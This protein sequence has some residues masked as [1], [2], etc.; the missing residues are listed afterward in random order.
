MLFHNEKKFRLKFSLESKKE[1]A[2]DAG[3][4]ASIVLLGYTNL[5][6]FLFVDVAEGVANCSKEEFPCAFGDQCIS[7]LQWQDGV[8]DCVDAS[9][10]GLT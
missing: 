6:L 7:L 4:V 5:L 10:E 1:T 9:D 2:D 8:E 3:M